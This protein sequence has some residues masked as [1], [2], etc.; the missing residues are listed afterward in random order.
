MFSS[1]ARL[2]LCSFSVLDFILFLDS[3]SSSS[4]YSSFFFFS[5]LMVY[6]SFSDF[7]I[8]STNPYYLHP[9]ENLSLVLVSSLL[10]DKNYHT[11]AR[12]MHIALISKNKEKFIDGTLTKPLVFNPLYAPWIRCNTMVLAWTHRSISDSIA[13]SVLW[14]DCATS[15]CKKICNFDFLMV[16]YSTFQIFKKIRTNFAKVLLMFQTILRKWR[17][18]G[19]NYKRIVLSLLDL[20]P[21]LVLVVSLHRFASI[22]NKIT[23]YVSS[24][25]WMRNSLTPSPKIMMMNP[26]PDIDKTFSLVIQ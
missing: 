13:K 2:H 23:L 4:S 15:V 17:L 18:C 14:I 1:S 20:A 11:W 5:P 6:Q 10:D 7:S 12:S 22:V 19:M 26:L 3:R 21:F 9:N 8:N 24:K 25:D 16:I